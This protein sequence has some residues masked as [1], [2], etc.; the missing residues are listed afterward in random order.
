MPAVTLAAS[1]RLE[2]SS[3]GFV[4][5]ARSAIEMRAGELVLSSCAFSSNGASLASGGALNIGSLERDAPP[6]FVTIRECG[7]SHN[8][9][10][11]GGAVAAWIAT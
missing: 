1:G 7:F 11:N 2:M 5:N 8:E 6:L 3:C 4:S 10:G 9:A